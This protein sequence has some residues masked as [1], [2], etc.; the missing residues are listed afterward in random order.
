MGNG[1]VI[2]ITIGY[3]LVVGV[4]YRLYEWLAG[5]PEDI[6]LLGGLLVMAITWPA[7]LPPT[8]GYMLICGLI[9]FMRVDE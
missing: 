4:T 7:S 1:E 3:L 2:L 6:D 9:K 8:L 5:D